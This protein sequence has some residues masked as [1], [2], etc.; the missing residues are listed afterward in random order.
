MIWKNK[1][2]IFDDIVDLKIQEEIKNCLF[3]PKNFYWFFVSDVSNLNKE[4]NKY[5][6]FVHQFVLNEKENSPFLK[7]ILPIIKNSCKK[8]EYNYK[9]IIQSR[10][11][12]QMPNN[13]N[14]ENILNDVHIDDIEDHMVVLY[15]VCDSDGETIIYK[16]YKNDDE[17]LKLIKKKTILPKQGRVVIFDGHYYHTSILPKKNVR[18]VINSNVF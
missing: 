7:L 8:I 16:N 1:L 4:K 13:L 18:C 9:K 11:F 14:N 17:N 15:Y 12:L 5:P 2:F 10:A 3:N 6:G